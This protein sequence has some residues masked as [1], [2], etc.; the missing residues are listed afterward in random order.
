MPQPKWSGGVEVLQARQIATRSSYFQARSFIRTGG[1]D[2]YSRVE[3]GRRKD[4]KR[5]FEMAMLDPTENALAQVKWAEDKSNSRFAFG[6][7]THNLLGAHEAAFIKAYYQSHDIVEAARHVDK[8]FDDEPF[9]A[10]AAMMHSYMG[11]ILDD[12]QSVIDV[13]DLGLRSN[14]NHPCLMNNKIFAEVSS[15]QVFEGTKRLSSPNYRRSQNT[16]LLRRA[17]RMRT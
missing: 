7:P 13:C 11:S 17:R 16:C 12:Y 4:A 1:S 3:D 2:W 9:S 10:I 15:G 6:N 14:P 5:R 8:W